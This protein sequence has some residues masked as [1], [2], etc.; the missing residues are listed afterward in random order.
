MGGFLTYLEFWDKVS[1]TFAIIERI[2]KD[3]EDIVLADFIIPT[4]KPY[5][6]IAF[7]DRYLLKNIHE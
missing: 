4:H 6:P 2:P 1:G 5:Q 3:G 7:L